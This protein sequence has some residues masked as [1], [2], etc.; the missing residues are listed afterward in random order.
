MGDSISQICILV[1][2][3]AIVA[4]L[5]ATLILCA[6]VLW[7]AAVAVPQPY[8]M[9]WPWAIW[10]LSLPIAFFNQPL[11]FAV[12]LPLSLSYR[13]FFRAY[14]VH[15]NGQSGF[16]LT[17]SFCVLNLLGLL[18]YVPKQ[19]GWLHN[20][21]PWVAQAQALAPAIGQWVGVASSITFLVLLMKMW[22]LR[23]QARDLDSF[24]RRGNASAALDA[25]QN[26]MYG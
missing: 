24:A 19:V 20:T 15:Q 23:R 18:R 25:L 4:A 7:S 17:L 5:F 14:G 8:R 16:G 9:R 6:W 21:W 22:G 26:Y 10:L 11:C 12:L 3:A 2:L 13:R 1:A